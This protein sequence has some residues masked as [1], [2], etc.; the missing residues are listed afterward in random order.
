MSSWLSR[1]QTNVSEI[2]IIS[3][4]FRGEAEGR[5]PGIHNPGLWL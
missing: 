3:L 2:R 4:S 5:E 1:P